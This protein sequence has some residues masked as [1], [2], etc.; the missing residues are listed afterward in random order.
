MSKFEVDDAEQTWTFPENH[1][2]LIHTRIMNGSLRNWEQYF[3]QSFKHCKPGG[4]VE[5]QELDII[6][7]TDDDSIPS[8]SYIYK[9]CANQEEAIQKIGLTLRIS[10]EKLRSWMQSAGFVN[11]TV[12]EFKVPIGTWPADRKLRELGAFQLVAMLDGI[13]GLTMALWTR[14]L[15][16][17]E[18]EIEVFLAKIRAEWRDRK[19]HSYWPLY[20]EAI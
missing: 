20:V 19:I 5:S 18:D 11:V 13:Q 4:W 14:F 1:F 17:T 3:Q 2:D 12:H 10:G 7:Y 16:W 15:G 8:D 9:W 6:A